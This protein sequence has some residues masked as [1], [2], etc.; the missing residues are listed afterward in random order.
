MFVFVYLCVHRPAVTLT[1]VLM[2]GYGQSAGGRWSN[3][4]VDRSVIPQRE[5]ISALFFK[6]V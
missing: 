6:C 2:A 4:V 5:N 3:K 1:A